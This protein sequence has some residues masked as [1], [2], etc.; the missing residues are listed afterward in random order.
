MKKSAK[1]LLSLAFSAG[2][3]AVGTAMYTTKSEPTVRAPHK[4]YDSTP[5]VEEAKKT[6]DAY[7]EAAL[8]SDVYT[9]LNTSKDIRYENEGMRK[10]EYY[11]VFADNPVK[12]IEVTRL[13]EVND[14]LVM[15]GLEMINKDG[16]HNI[17][18][19]PVYK[20]NGNWRVVVGVEVGSYK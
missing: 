19:L 10:K 16:N 14:S 17:V 11:R 5:V 13:K 9:M 15:V 20:E 12:E 4:L 6:I 8:H 7:I 18:T 1:I 2:V 3:I